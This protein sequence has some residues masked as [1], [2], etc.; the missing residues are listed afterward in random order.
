MSRRLGHLQIRSEAGLLE[1]LLLVP[2]G[3]RRGAALVCQAHPQ[4]GGTTHAK[5]VYHPARGLES[6]GFS[7]PCFNF[8]GTGKSE[9]H[10]SGGPGEFEDASV[11][12]AWLE[13]RHAA[14]RSSWLASPSGRG[15]ACVPVLDTMPSRRS[16]PSTRPSR[17]TTSTS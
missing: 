12:L 17:S 15:S 13:Q 16:W 8:R 2:A 9:G 10:S 4:H 6:A 5:A 1:A 11:A 3:R 14:F 7:V